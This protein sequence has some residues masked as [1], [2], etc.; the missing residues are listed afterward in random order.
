[1]ARGDRNSERKD[2]GFRKVQWRRVGKIGGRATRT[3]G[4]ISGF[5]SWTVTRT[6]TSD[7][8]DQSQRNDW[9]SG[10]RFRSGPNTQVRIV[11]RVWTVP[12]KL[13]TEVELGAFMVSNPDP[14]N[15]S[16]SKTSCFCSKIKKEY[17]Y[18]VPFWIKN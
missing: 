16:R 5:G 2:K 12:G 14:T 17:M 15:D 6:Q 1:M 3:E 9:I 18:F 13:K 10:F 7:G 8:S 4:G 11:D